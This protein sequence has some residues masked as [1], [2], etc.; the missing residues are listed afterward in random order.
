MLKS[1]NADALREYLKDANNKESFRDI[2]N[3]FLSQARS[4]KEIFQLR[5]LNENGDEIVRVDRSKYAGDA[6]LVSRDRLQNKKNRY[7]F[8]EVSKLGDGS[9]WNSKIDLNEENGKIE[10]PIKPTF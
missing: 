7:Y 4:R 3:L 2:N 9:I 1:L 8:K 6:N 5:Y 10:E